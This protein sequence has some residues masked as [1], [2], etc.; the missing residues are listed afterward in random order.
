MDGVRSR[1]RLVL[2]VF[3][4]VGNRLGGPSVLVGIN[5]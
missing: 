2:L 1:Y 4:E 3:T 5:P